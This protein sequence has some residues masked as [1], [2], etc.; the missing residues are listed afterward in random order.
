MFIAL[1]GQFV[2]NACIL[3]YMLL[4]IYNNYRTA[5]RIRKEHRYF[6]KTLSAVITNMQETDANLE[7]YKRTM[8]SLMVAF[9][10][11]I[12]ALEAKINK[13]KD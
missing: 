9:S 2:I 4:Q 10:K 11:E 3:S 6:D 1:Y 13:R 7:K 8:A 12:D 5:E